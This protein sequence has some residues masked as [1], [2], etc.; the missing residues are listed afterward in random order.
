MTSARVHR[1]PSQAFPEDRQNPVSKMNEK[2]GTSQRAYRIL[3]TLELL[4]LGAQG[5]SNQNHKGIHHT[6]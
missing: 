4:K 5:N 1:I 3:T 6:F 2:M